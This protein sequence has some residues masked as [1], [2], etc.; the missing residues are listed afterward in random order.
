M[1]ATHCDKFGLYLSLF[2]AF[3]FLIFVKSIRLYVHN[4]RQHILYVD[5]FLNLRQHLGRSAWHISIAND[6]YSW[7]SWP[8]AALMFYHGLTLAA[9]RSFDCSKFVTTVLNSIRLSFCVCLAACLLQYVVG[10]V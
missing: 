4:L 6:N 8:G 2:R 5:L 7:L 3:A 10:S 9:P 1:Q